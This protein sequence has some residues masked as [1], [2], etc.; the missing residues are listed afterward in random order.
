[1]RVMAPGVSIGTWIVWGI[2][3]AAELSTNIRSKRMRK[4]NEATFQQRDR[5]SGAV[6]QIG[7]YILFF[8]DYELHINQIGWVTGSWLI[9]GQLITLSGVSLRYWALA[10]L[11][12]FYTPKVAVQ[13]GQNI[14]QSGPYRIIRHPAYSGGLLI[15]FGLGLAL[16][17]WLGAVIA[18][19]TLF[20]IYAYRIAVEEK[21]LQETFGNVY[22]DYMRKTSR[23]IPGVW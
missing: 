20:F 7:T 22:L 6:L 14:V 9:A 3:L 18:V 13:D 1:M 2:W 16:N 10:V 21:L 11:G 19:I 12:R 4:Q 5:G 17:T 8:M 23:L 15:M